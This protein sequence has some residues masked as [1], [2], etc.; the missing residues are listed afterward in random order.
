MVETDGEENTEKVLLSAQNN[1]LL[2][3]KKFELLSVSPLF[4]QQLSHQ[5]VVGRFIR[6]QVASQYDLKSGEQWVT[7]KQLQQYPF[8]QFINQYLVNNKEQS[9]F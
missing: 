6:V 8:P 1:G 5:L 9:L 7:K 4:K 3:K 2:E